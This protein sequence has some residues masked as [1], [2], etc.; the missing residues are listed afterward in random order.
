MAITPYLPIYRRSNIVMAHGQGS[1]LYDAAGKRYL[2]FAAGIAVN[3]FGHGHPAL[4]EA[5]KSQGEKL[6]HCSNQFMTPQ[7][8]KFAAELVAASFADSVF[9]CSS[10]AEAVEA[11]IKFLR[12]YHFE[13]GASYRHRI[14]T[15]EG[16][17]H[18]RT[19][20]GISAGGNDS[21]RKGFGQL[22]NGFDRVAFNDVAAVENAI[23]K[24]TAGILIEPIQG[25]G[26][27]RAFDLDF[28]RQIRALCDR[29]GIL[30]MCDEV[31]CGYG[32]PGMLF[33]FERAGISPDIA[34]V[35]KA[36]GGGFPLGATLLTERVGAVLPAGSHGSTYGSNP[37]AMA[38]ASKVLE[39]L[40]APGFLTQVSTMGARLKAGLEALQ[41]QHPEVIQ[42]V[43]GFGLML[44]LVPS[45]DARL[46]AAKLLEKGLTSA[47]SVT[48]VLRLM[49][50]LNVSAAEVDEALVK[51]KEALCDISLTGAR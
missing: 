39:L 14:I 30:L 24:N 50:P 19:Y 1:Y 51:L 28:L 10:G 8:E 7:L 4:V 48:N 22:L 33:A 31:Q 41:A 34:S 43:R 23:S 36:I 32:R 13:T 27:V 15:F 3:A 9:F 38:I 12:R 20:G 35:A 42:E 2:D 18:G 25:E 16:G 11:G 49:P 37:L 47:P 17:F 44:G 40:L 29:E 21:A 5:L 45:A 26:G 46:L 6:W